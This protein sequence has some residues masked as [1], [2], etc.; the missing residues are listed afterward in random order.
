MV[1]G[2]VG[3]DKTKERASLAG[4]SLQMVYDKL[5]L[6]RYYPLVVVRCLSSQSSSGQSLPRGAP[7]CPYR[8]RHFKIEETLV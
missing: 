2:L 1:V 5:R 7:S 3:K 8:I 6:T 4:M